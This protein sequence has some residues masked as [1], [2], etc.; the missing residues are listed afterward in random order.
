MKSP[1]SNPK[2]SPYPFSQSSLQDYVDCPRRFQ[3]RY[4]LRLSWPAVK[5][6]PIQ[7]Y[8][9]QMQRGEAFHQCLQRYFL[10]I[11][12]ERLAA[13]TLSDPL[14]AQW[15]RDFQSENPVPD[16]YAKFTEIG[17]ACPIGEHRLVARYD[18]LAVADQRF[19][20]FDWKT[21]KNRPKQAWLQEN[22]QTRVYPFVLVRAGAHLNHGTPLQPE[23]VEMVYWF[24][25]F[26]SSPLR[27]P[28]NQEKYGADEAYLSGL[29][30]KI[31]ACGENDFPLTANLDHC[32]YCVYR[33]FCDRG[34]EAGSLDDLEGLAWVDLPAGDEIE[35]V[36]LDL[37]QIAEIEF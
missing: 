17:L 5:S 37:D 11:T 22:L 9:Q 13:S 6:Q 31:T 33:S 32:R 3:L 36:D 4:L 23:Q 34:V 26:P 20:I 29:V 8:E 19:L 35:T 2:S 27:F 30:Q 24:S 12:P 14:L 16:G 25:N 21:G 7:E 10:G 18:L 28:Y 15:W 1:T